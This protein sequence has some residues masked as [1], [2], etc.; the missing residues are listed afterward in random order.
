MLLRLREVLCF[1]N[2]HF[3]LERIHNFQFIGSLLKFLFDLINLIIKIVNI[4]ALL[5]VSLLKNFSS[6]LH[7]W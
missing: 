6:I 7:F 5:N 2:A 3:A 1:R 4:F